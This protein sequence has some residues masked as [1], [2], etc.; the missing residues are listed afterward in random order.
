MNKYQLSRLGQKTQ[1]SNAKH[2]IMVKYRTQVSDGEGGFN[3]T[4]VNRYNI[5]AEI[6]PMSA[7]QRFEYSSVNV[8]ASHRIK[9]LGN[10]DFQDNTKYVNDSWSITW[11]GIL[12]ANIQIHYQIDGGSW[13]EI[14]ANETNDGSY[15]WTIPIAAIGKNIIVRVMHLTDTSS[16]VLTDPY[17]IVA[18]NSRDGLPAEA[19]QIEWTLGNNTR[20]FEILTVENIQ[21]RNVQ[22]V[23]TCLEKR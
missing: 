16:Y 5:W 7:S 13:V 2:K 20:T 23:L 15:D 21:E 19:D 17:N 22:A 9:I 12:G 4:W 6:C 11:S 3:I 1:S 18:E 8:D 10:L 14:E